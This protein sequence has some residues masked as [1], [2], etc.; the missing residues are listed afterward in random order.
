MNTEPVHIN[1]APLP[2][3]NFSELIRYNV[4]PIKQK[5]MARHLLKRQKAII[6]KFIKDNT[7]SKDSFERID[8]VFTRGRHRLDTDDLPV[9]LWL[10][11]EEIN[12]TEILY[13]E[14]ERYMSDKCSEAIEL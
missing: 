3:C 2:C 11:I 7:H 8:S 1:S 9:E 13:Q 5:D 6:D 12:D 10:K 14:V 4:K